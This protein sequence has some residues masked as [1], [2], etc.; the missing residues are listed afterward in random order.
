M[1]T[2]AHLGRAA[3]TAESRESYRQKMSGEKNPAW[4]GGVT[5]K[6][7]KGNY[8]PTIEVRCPPEFSIMAKAN[9]YV[10]QHRLAMAI[11]IRRPLTRIEVVHHENHDPQV[12]DRTNLELWPDNRSHKLAEH[13]RFA[14]GAVNQWSPRASAPR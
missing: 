2:I 3:W 13:G 1:K 5:F 14:I 10:S 8:K 4:K 12:N 11:W 7:H 6:R 9:G